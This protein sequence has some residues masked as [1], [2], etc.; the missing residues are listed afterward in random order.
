VPYALQ[1]NPGE[2]LWASA[3]RSRN[4]RDCCAGLTVSN[5]GGNYSALWVGDGATATL[6]GCSFIGNNV[7]DAVLNVLT[8][9]TVVRLQRCTFTGNKAEY[10][11]LVFSASKQAVYVDEATLEVI[12]RSDT[13]GFTSEPLSAA[14][15]DRPGLTTLSDWYLFARQVCS[16]S[17][18]LLQRG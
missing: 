18:C 6:V 1:P 14:P 3:S 13:L 8:I 9:G 2:D 11:V 16:S 10:L 7:R 15:A 4:L 12:E 5:F 17:A